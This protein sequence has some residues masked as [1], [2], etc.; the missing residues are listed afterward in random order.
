MGSGKREMGRKR[1]PLLTKVRVGK[2]ETK[3]KRMEQAAAPEGRNEAR[4]VNKGM[5]GVGGLG[6][7]CALRIGDVERDV[8][9]RIG[10]GT[11]A[12][13]L[14]VV[15]IVM[16]GRGKQDVEQEIGCDSSNCC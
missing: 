3:W 8:E 4:L 7:A 14:G 13:N 1:K 6:I 9:R 10:N 2:E 16:Y 15:A 5:I 11:D 12:R